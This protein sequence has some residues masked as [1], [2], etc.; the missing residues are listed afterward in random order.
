[1]TSERMKYFLLFQRCFN[2]L[3]FDWRLDRS[4]TSSCT[5]ARV[6]CTSLSSGTFVTYSYA[7]ERTEETS[8]SDIRWPHSSSKLYFFPRYA[9]SSF[10]WT[11]RYAQNY[12]FPF[13]LHYLVSLSNS[14]YSVSSS[15][16]P[17]QSNARPKLGQNA[18]KISGRRRRTFCALSLQ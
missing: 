15:S 13:Q 11:T 9:V 6:V 14:L 3:I 4:N 8:W 10:N 5:Q 18:H 12:L 1:M 7:Y 17:L 2:C 16:L